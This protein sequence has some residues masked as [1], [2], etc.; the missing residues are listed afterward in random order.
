MDEIH[1]EEVLKYIEK[2][3]IFME[4]SCFQKGHANRI[5]SASSSIVE[6]ANDKLRLM[7]KSEKE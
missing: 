6:I 3:S 1:N 5:Q 7:R 2:E 4:M